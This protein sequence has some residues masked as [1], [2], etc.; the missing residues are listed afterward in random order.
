MNLAIADLDTSIEL[1][2]EALIQIVGAW[3]YVR[4]SPIKTYGWRNGRSS[5]HTTYKWIGFFGLGG[6][7]K[8]RIRTT[9]QLWTQARYVTHQKQL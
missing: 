7:K 8:F 5:Y 3:K 2:R 6:V 9:R 1:D 4:S